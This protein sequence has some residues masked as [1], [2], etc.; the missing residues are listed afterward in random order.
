MEQAEYFGYSL[1]KPHT[2]L[3]TLISAS[4]SINLPIK[5]EKEVETEY[6]KKKRNV[7]WT[8]LNVGS[9]TLFTNI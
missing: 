1:K 8:A 3:L 5:T 2:F 7:S 6:K 4:I 9:Q